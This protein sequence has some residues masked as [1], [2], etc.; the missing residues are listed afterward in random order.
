MHGVVTDAR[1]IGEPSPTTVHEGGRHD[2]QHDLLVLSGSAPVLPR[3]GS[4]I[5]CDASA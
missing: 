4:S 2:H 3:P 1:L 5:V